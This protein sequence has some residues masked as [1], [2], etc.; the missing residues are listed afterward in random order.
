MNKYIDAL[1]SLKYSMSIFHSKCNSET[2]VS[3]TENWALLE[4][5]A[6][7][8]TPHKPAETAIEYM[9]PNCLETLCFKPTM[10]FRKYPRCRSCGQSL[11]W[12]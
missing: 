5:L 8:E 12:G 11:Y 10:T 2:P 3:E 6:E 9:C 1:K 7:K 4:E